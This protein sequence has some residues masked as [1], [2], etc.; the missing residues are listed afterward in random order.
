MQRRR[1]RFTLFQKCSLLF[2]GRRPGR[3]GAIHNKTRPCNPTQAASY[4]PRTAVLS[5]FEANGFFNAAA[6]QS[7]AASGASSCWH[8]RK[9]ERKGN[10]VK[11]SNHGSHKQKSCKL[12]DT[13]NKGTT[14]AAALT[15]THDEEPTGPQ[16][17]LKFFAAARIVMCEH[18]Q[19]QAFLCE[20]YRL[21]PTPS[22]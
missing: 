4:A 1:A 17:S 20:Q 19:H 10:V 15:H 16:H 6:I 13:R 9:K 8:E 7:S 5:G 22:R 18:H 21:S 11:I 12:I 3:S 14:K 2:D